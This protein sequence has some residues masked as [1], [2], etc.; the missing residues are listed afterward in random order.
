MVRWC[1]GAVVGG[2]LLKV[3]ACIAV[4]HDA[5]IMVMMHVITITST[6]ENKI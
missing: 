2:R 3:H 4:R 1:G 5:M 6:T